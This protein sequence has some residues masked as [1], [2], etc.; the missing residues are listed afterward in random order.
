MKKVEIA[1]IVLFAMV[2]LAV[3]LYVNVTTGQDAKQTIDFSYVAGW[4]VLIIAGS[5]WAVT[6]I[7][8]ATSK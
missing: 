8:R 3:Q 4:V 1:A 7:T 6:V 2:Y 5:I